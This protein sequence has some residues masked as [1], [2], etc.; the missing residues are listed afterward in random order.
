MK[1]KVRILHLES[2][3]KKYIC[4]LFNFLGH[5]SINRFLIPTVAYILLDRMIIQD[6]LYFEVLLEIKVHV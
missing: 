5:K 4:Y 1:W 6:L 3:N 2:G